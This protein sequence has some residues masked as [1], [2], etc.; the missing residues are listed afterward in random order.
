MEGER[1]WWWWGERKDMRKCCAPLEDCT[2][3]PEQAHHNDIGRTRTQHACVA[4]T[5]GNGTTVYSV[6]SVQNSQ[7]CGTVSAP[8]TIK[9]LLLILGFSRSTLRTSSILAST[10]QS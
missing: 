2:D 10:S 6:Q 7:S 9:T 5:V 4:C 8:R 3:H 1:R